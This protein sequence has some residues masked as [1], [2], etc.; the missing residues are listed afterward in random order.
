[1]TAAEGRADVAVAGISAGVAAGLITE[2]QSAGAIV[3]QIAQ[4]AEDL[5]RQRPRE[6]LD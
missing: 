1:V 4:E 3:R 2:A 5:L 6:L